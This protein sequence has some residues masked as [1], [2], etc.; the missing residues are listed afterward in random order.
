MA[1]FKVD[2]AQAQRL[3]DATGCSYAEAVKTLRDDWETDHGIEHDWDMSEEEHKKAMKNANSGEKKQKK[4]TTER[5]RK[6]N[7]TK[8][9]II[10]ALFQFFAEN[11][12]FSFENVQISNPER[13][14]SFAFG[15]EKYEITLIQKRKPKNGG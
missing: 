14:I 12:Q 11:E 13:M 9:G 6:E 15:D 1:T 7:P 10:S 4:G 2:E 3:I 5:K 8:R